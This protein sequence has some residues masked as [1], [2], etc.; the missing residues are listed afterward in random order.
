MIVP[1]CFTT[2]RSRLGYGKAKRRRH[3]GN[4]PVAHDDH[5][6]EE[7]DNVDNEDGNACDI[8]DDY[9]DDDDDDDNDDDA[10]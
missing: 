6:H 5:L 10:R 7:D 2:I 9:N 4:Q 8:N 1:S 3:D